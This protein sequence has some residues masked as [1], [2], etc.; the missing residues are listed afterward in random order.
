MRVSQIHSCN[1]GVV[2]AG[3]KTAKKLE[4]I[5]INIETNDVDRTARLQLI[6]D[7]LAKCKRLCYLEVRATYGNGIV[8]LFGAVE[9]GLSKLKRDTLTIRF[10]G[11]LRLWE[12][13]TTAME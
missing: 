5:Q 11:G 10:A 8:S 2:H 7:M 6:E 12:S 13:R 4:K 9:R 1:I 3:I